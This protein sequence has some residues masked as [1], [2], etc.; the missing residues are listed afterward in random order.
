MRISRRQRFRPLEFILQTAH[1]TGICLH[2][3]TKHKSL[4]GI[5]H[6][7]SQLIWLQVNPKVS[8]LSNR[9]LQ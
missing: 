4:A 5:G 7:A 3:P 9:L 2:G 1:E 8:L 6:I